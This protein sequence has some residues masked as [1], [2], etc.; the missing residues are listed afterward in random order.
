VKFSSGDLPDWHEGPPQRSKAL[1]VG[2][3]MILADEL[4]ERRDPPV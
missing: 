1:D 4:L 3:S 2:L